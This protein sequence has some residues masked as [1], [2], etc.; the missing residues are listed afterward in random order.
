MEHPKDH[1]SSPSHI[2]MEAVSI[3]SDHALRMG[4]HA[5]TT[6][7]IIISAEERLRQRIR[8]VA[9]VALATVFFAISGLV[10]LGANVTT[11][12]AKKA[13]SGRGNS[14]AGLKLK[15]TGTPKSVSF[16]RHPSKHHRSR[17]G[18]AKLRGGSSS[19]RGVA[20][21]YGKQFHNR[22]TAS[23]VR[24]NTHAM[25]AAH[26]SLPFGTKVRVT[27]LA[28][29]R[30][31]VVEITDRGPFA[32]GRIIDLSHAAAEELGM[33]QSGVANVQLEVIP[34]FMHDASKDIAFA[35]QTPAVDRLASKSINRLKI[36]QPKADTADVSFYDAENVG[37]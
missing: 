16:H 8:A 6:V 22:L 5:I 28:N 21:W 31:C 32:R 20:S 27:N 33:M 36:L 26:R 11:A 25:M 7:H 1:S 14:A 35:L 17:I 19:M 13:T 10:S 4:D 9:R 2:M 23:G 18:L 29:Q 3:V 24:F 15:R 37:H 34:A 12:F 30:S